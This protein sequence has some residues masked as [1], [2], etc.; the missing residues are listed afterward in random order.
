[1]ALSPAE[2]QLSL[3]FIFTYWHWDNKSFFC[4]G[5]CCC[6]YAVQIMYGYV[7]AYTG[8]LL[9]RPFASILNRATPLGLCCLPELLPNVC[10]WACP[11]WYPQLH[12]VGQRQRTRRSSLSSVTPDPLSV[13]RHVHPNIGPRQTTMPLPSPDTHSLQL[14]S[15][16]TDEPLAWLLGALDRVSRICSDI[17]HRDSHTSTLSMALERLLDQSGKGNVGKSKQL[18]SLFLHT[19]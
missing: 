9:A 4:L 2:I 7:S 14:F 8:C 12:T 16:Q 10:K 1:M 18:V 5:H 15:I 13:T 3:L 6:V 17:L 19:F 11:Q